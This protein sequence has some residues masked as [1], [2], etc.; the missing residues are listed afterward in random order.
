MRVEAPRDVAADH[1]EVR[2]PDYVPGVLAVRVVG[3]VALE[4]QVLEAPVGV[5]DH[6]ALDDPGGRRE[7]NEGRPPARRPHHDRQRGGPRHPGVEPVP[8]RVRAAGEH[9]GVPG[10]GVSDGGLELSGGGHPDGPLR[11][12]RRGDEEQEGARC[13]GLHGHRITDGVRSVTPHL[14]ALTAG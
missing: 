3:A 12:G 9:D 6:E 10:R 5:R 2:L 13:G 11:G 14:R 7:A 8:E 4:H 1:R